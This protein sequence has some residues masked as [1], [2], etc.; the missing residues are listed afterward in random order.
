MVF[1][2]VGTVTEMRYS[3]EQPPMTDIQRKNAAHYLDYKKDEPS[4]MHRGD[5]FYMEGCGC[6][7][8]D[9]FRMGNIEDILTLSHQSLHLANAMVRGI[10]ALDDHAE[11]LAFTQESI[12]RKALNAL[13]GKWEEK[14]GNPLSQVTTDYALAP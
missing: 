11:T 10:G 12:M 3:L 8:L 13:A 7:R 2:F 5:T 1:V 4:A 14:T 9:D 6:I